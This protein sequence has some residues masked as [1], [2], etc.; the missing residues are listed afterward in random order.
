MNRYERL[1]ENENLTLEELK[2]KI[3]NFVKNEM[4]EHEIRSYLHDHGFDDIERWTLEE[5]QELVIDFMIED[6]DE[7]V[8]MYL[9]KVQKNEGT[10][11]ISKLADDAYQHLQ[12][13]I[14]EQINH[15]ALGSDVDIDD[16]ED[17]LD[18]VT[19]LVILKLQA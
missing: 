5:Q 14:M 11:K 10:E 2:L 8:N 16:L 3:T 4:P 12:D 18:D 15:G 1:T 9:P 6:P 19:K 17:T 7:T 13:F